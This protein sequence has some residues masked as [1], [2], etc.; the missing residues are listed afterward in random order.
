MLL[1][2]MVRQMNYLSVNS[3][4]LVG[5]LV[6]FLGDFLGNVGEMF[7][8]EGAGNDSSKRD[9]ACE[10]MGKVVGLMREIKEIVD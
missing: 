5:L 7:G 4:V 1:E 10:V 6:L 8:G 3:E 2:M 9:E